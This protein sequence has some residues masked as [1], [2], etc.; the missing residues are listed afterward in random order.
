MLA[1]FKDK[2]FF[3]QKYNLF[4][5]TI[6]CIVITI[7]ILSNHSF[8]FQKSKITDSSKFYFKFQRVHLDITSLVFINDLSLSTD[9]EVAKT[10]LQD[11]GIQAGY[12]YLTALNIEGKRYGS[13]FHDLNIIAYT[14]IGYDKSITTRLILGGAFRMSEKSSE[15][16]YP[17]TGLKL[18]VS[19][20]FNFSEA[21][22]LYFRYS[23]IYN[24]THE[25]ISAIGLGLSIGWPK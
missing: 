21:V 6:Y 25:G 20:L 5:K 16:K 19:F 17:V 24:S 13:P 7:F 3:L 18:G 14:S 10:K 22:K 1:V 4:C 15:K 11:F 23:G 9:F 2:S 12:S 8:G